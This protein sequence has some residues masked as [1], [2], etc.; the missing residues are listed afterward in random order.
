V[1][2]LG[3]AGCGSAEPPPTHPPEGWIAFVNA[4]LGGSEGIFVMNPD[5]SG[6]RRISPATGPG[7]SWSP[8]GSQ[9]AFTSNPGISVMDADGS[10]ATRLAE[11]GEY[12]AWSPDGRQI[13]FSIRPNESL[14][15]DPPDEA[16]IALLKQEHLRLM[17]ADGSDVTGLSSGPVSDEW[18]SWSPDGTRLAFD[19]NYVGEMHEGDCSGICLIDADGSGLIQLPADGDVPWLFHIPMNVASVS[20][21]VTAI[22]LIR[23]LRDLGIPVTRSIGAYLPQYWSV[24]AG[25]GSI[26]F[27]NLLRHEAGLGGGL[28]SPGPADFATDKSPTREAVERMLRH[29]LGISMSVV[30]LLLRLSMRKVE[31]NSFRAVTCPYRLGVS[32][33]SELSCSLSRTWIGRKRRL[34]LQD[35]RKL[36]RMEKSTPNSVSTQLR[37]CRS[38][39]S[40]S[41]IVGQR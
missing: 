27:E 4:G 3:I 12:P 33:R 20:K 40:T 18:P 5:G 7:L 6:R 8:D 11:A 14:S 32:R 17:N 35:T 26:T 36:M 41:H 38:S 21:F 29:R 28:S 23:L 31:E 22:A 16:T 30:S 25:A 13:A 9:L 15:D 34:L 19:R 10:G 24:G 39:S 2:A 37:A 1:L